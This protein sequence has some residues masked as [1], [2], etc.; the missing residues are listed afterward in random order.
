MVVI[1]VRGSNQTYVILSYRVRTCL[2][3]I[4]LP[5]GLLLQLF[6]RHR[7]IYSGVGAAPEISSLRLA[8]GA[9]LRVKR[10]QRGLF[11]ARLPPRE[12]L[13]PKLG[14]FLFFFFSSS[15]LELERNRR[16]D[17]KCCGSSLRRPRARLVFRDWFLGHLL[18]G[19][20]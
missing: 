15:R 14:R 3:N 1:F 5:P 18:P 11:R 6:V 7:K 8:C 9:S 12:L 13:F 20:T 17:W 4:N 10:R 16:V 2:M 19:A